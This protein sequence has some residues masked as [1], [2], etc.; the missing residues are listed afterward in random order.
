MC[1]EKQFKK[2]YLR[3]YNNIMNDKK[4]KRYM[5]LEERSGNECVYLNTKRF[6][7]QIL[8]IMMNSNIEYC[9]KHELKK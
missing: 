3:K 8:Q 9:E 7:K 4:L 6:T 5:I 1:F 2:G